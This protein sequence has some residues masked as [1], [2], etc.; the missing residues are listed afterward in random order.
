MEFRNVPFPKISS[1]SNLGHS[2]PMT[3]FV[4]IAMI[5]TCAVSLCYRLS[6][7]KCFD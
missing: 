3:W 7:L 1:L 4:V 6:C 2:A 5:A